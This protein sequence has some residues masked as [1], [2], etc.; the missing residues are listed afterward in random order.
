[1]PKFKIKTPRRKREWKALAKEQDIV[2]A[3]QREQIDRLEA[4]AADAHVAAH[5]K[6]QESVMQLVAGAVGDGCPADS[7][8]G[9]LEAIGRLRR[10]RDEARGATATNHKM[11]G[12]IC[13]QRDAAQAERDEAREQLAD[14]KAELSDALARLESAFTLNK[15]RVATI[16][17]QGIELGRLRA[18]PGDYRKG[19]PVWRAVREVVDTADGETA[20]DMADDVCARLSDGALRLTPLMAAC[21]S[22]GSPGAYT[23]PPD[24]AACVEALRAA[25]LRLGSSAWPGQVRAYAVVADWLR[26]EAARL[27]PPEGYRPLVPAADGEPHEVASC[28][29]VV[30]DALE[31]GGWR[32]VTE[33][34]PAMLDSVLVVHE[35][36]VM[37]GFW[38]HLP[39]SNVRAWMLTDE[40]GSGWTVYSPSRP[41]AWQPLPPPAKEPTPC[42]Y[43]YPLIKKVCGGLEEDHGSLLGHAFERSA[44]PPAN[45][46]AHD[47]AAPPAAV[48]M[49][50]AEA[51]DGA[52]S[53][54][55]AWAADRVCAR[56]SDG[57][58]RLSPLLAA[59]NRASVGGYEGPRD[60]AE[61]VEMLRR[62]LRLTSGSVIDAAK[63]LGALADKVRATAA[64]LLPTPAWR[65]L[66]DC[67]DVVEAAALPRGER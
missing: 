59:C 21:N 63:T 46:P 54:F 9:I 18:Q 37:Y 28:L 56:L 35:G 4:R 31:R 67:W 19:G 33:E 36:R 16:E 6:G 20:D 14:T 43:V 1:M 41:T 49:E 12:V 42:G 25:G 60:D 10:E 52:D 11:V 2:I 44:A 57:A 64:E 7:M 58:F 23:G 34:E 30:R 5:G 8:T 61:A 13:K 48:A 32:P 17:A 38:Q 45:E 22:A 26:A 27:V 50:P 15:Q 47:R 40:M 65:T 3:A 29:E 53:A 51:A 55:P 66:A 24:D 62:H 39:R